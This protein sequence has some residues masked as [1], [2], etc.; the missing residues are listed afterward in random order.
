MDAGYQPIPYYGR[1]LC[2]QDPQFE[3]VP[4][5]KYIASAIRGDDKNM[6][7]MFVK[8]VTEKFAEDGREAEVKLPTNLAPHAHVFGITISKP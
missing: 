5:I 7:H 6:P 1:I 8:L 2:Y 3:D 4:T